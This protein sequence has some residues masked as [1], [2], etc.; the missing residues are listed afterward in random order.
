VASWW[1][2]VWG[3]LFTTNGAGQKAAKDFAKKHGL[4]N[5][6]GPESGDVSKVTGAIG[7]ISDAVNLTKLV[8]LNVSD[9]RMWRSLG[10]LLLGVAL[11][12]LG[13]VVWNRKALAAAAPLAE[14]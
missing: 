11:M 5:T 9:Y 1:E 3:T 8:W 7:D 2:D 10:W 6:V 13:F 4:P 14:L 12:I